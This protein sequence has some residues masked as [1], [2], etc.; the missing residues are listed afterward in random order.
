MR[1]AE[2]ALAARSI[3]ERA[4]EG[5]ALEVNER[6]VDPCARLLDEAR[7]SCRGR[8]ARGVR[9]CPLAAR[10]GRGGKTSWSVSSWPTAIA[11]N[12]SSSSTSVTPTAARA[13]RGGVRRPPS[14]SRLPW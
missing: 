10:R 9:R 11:S 13:L 8:S 14:A 1:L 12:A 7:R 6:A 3:A 4:C 2:L 5:R